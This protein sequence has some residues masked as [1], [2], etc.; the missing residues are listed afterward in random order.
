MASDLIKKIYKDLQ[1]SSR[2]IHKLHK[3]IEDDFN[4]EQGKQW[5]DDDIETLRVAGVKALTINKLKPIIKLITGLE[6]QSRSDFVA[7]PE[8]EEDDIASNIVTRL[9]KNVVKTSSVEIKLSEQ[10]KHGAIGGLCFL[11]P[12]IDYSY[13]IINGIMKFK[14]VSPLDVYF[15]PDFQEYDM[16]DSKFMVKITRDL[17]ESEIK[18]LFPKKSDQKKI[19]DS[20]FTKVDFDSLANIDDIAQVLDYPSANLMENKLDND[21]EK[22]YDLLDYYYQDVHDYYYVVVQEKG[23]V[24]QFEDKDEAEQVAQKIGGVVA[25]KT[26]PVIRHAQCIGSIELY[27]DICWCQPK[28]KGYPLLPYFAELITEKL[29]S[30]DLRIQGVV[31]S[32]KDL[33]EEFN[34][35]RTQELRHLNASVNSGDFVPKGSLDEDNMQKLKKFGS[36]PGVVIEFDSN[37]GLPERVFPAPLSQGHKQLAEENAQDLKEASGVNPDLLANDSQSQSGRAILL[38]Q[39]QGLVMV[40]EMLDNFGETKKMCGKFILSQISELFTIESALKVLG[41]AFI[42]D[43]FTVPVNIILERGLQKVQDGKEQELT[44]LERATMLQYP[45]MASNQPIVDEMNNLVTAIDLDS[46][47]ML[48]NN[49]LTSE[50][51]ARYDI[52]I[53]EGPYQDTIRLSNFMDLKDLASQGVMIPPQILIEQSMLPAGEKKKI[54]KQMEQMMMAQ[55]APA[56]QQPS[57]GEKQ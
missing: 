24:K 36:S 9:L 31:R 41:D 21:I 1:Y 12:Y 8:G 32:V 34:K 17:S 26:C 3:Q 53:G 47:I 13:D 50:D 39:R 57:R 4:F 2:K 44:E 30:F 14:K 49:I 29:D 7:L 15:D 28:W 23:L 16:S 40:Q 37:K 52:A 51:L 43:N 54:V 48:I 55:Q 6:R 22:K 25:Q 45:E 33:Q 56:K 20:G 27:D 46:A 42:A 10:F 19:F 35:R 5:K 38:K 18:I 11:E